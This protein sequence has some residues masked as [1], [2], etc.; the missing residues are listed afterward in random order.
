MI[1][2]QRLTKVFG[3]TRSVD[4]VSFQAERGEVLGFLG[5]NGAGKS[6]TMRLLAGLIRPTSGRAS[7]GG[8]DMQA[9]T[10]EQ[11]RVLGYLPEG[12]PLYGDMT[13]E[14]YLIYMG[15]LKGL[16]ATEAR[17]EMDRTT[18]LLNL[19]KERRRLLGNLSKG[20]RQR[21]AFA[22]ALLGK[23]PVLLLDEPTVGLDPSQI[24]D[25]RQLIRSFAGETTVLFSSHIL[26]EIELTCSRIV[27][28]ANGRVAAQGTP[29]DLVAAEAGEGIA[30]LRGPRPQL[31]RVLTDLPGARVQALWHVDEL[32]LRFDVAGTPDLRPEIA[33][34]AVQAGVDVLEVGTRGARLED[35][36]L[37]AIGKGASAA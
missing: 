30:R 27:I 16:D 5:P 32:E 11:R 22:Q 10:P 35:V 15:G 36:F 21:A 24:N 13:L 18:S 9:A 8:V 29:R 33:R 7:I 6:T 19:T 1:E 4:D 14:S 37:R 12:A 17:R 28:I 31:E 20:T 26:P 34:R 2:V 3:N 25:V 23:P